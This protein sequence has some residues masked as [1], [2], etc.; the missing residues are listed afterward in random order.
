M[1]REQAKALGTFIRTHRTE[2]GLSTRDLAAAVGVDM[3]QIVRLERGTVA[4]PK[5]DL[6]SRIA[7]EVGV[8]VTDLYRLAGYA[9]ELPSFVPYLRAK[10]GDLPDD[11]VDQM[12]RYFR[13]VARRHGTK[14][15]DDGEDE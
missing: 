15:P 1:D 4:S 5:A 6:L 8:E 2:R 12:E 13:R 7:P 9:V 10:Y 14:G 11:A 3:A